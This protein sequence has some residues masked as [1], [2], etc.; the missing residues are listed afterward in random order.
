MMFFCVFERSIY[1]LCLAYLLVI[2]LSTD[3]E[4]SIAWFRP[5]RYMRA[6]LS[7]SFWLPFAT[8]SF[9]LYLFHLQIINTWKA[10]SARA[11]FDG[12]V[13]YEDVRDC[14]FWPIFGSFEY[15]FWVIFIIAIAMSALSFIYV[16]KPG[17][18]ARVVF[19]NKY[20]K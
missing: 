9:S 4:S 3:P 2:M 15:E 18:D 7:W 5:T 11:F 16:E 14:K 10:N 17:I 1:G 20:A 13:S 6:F 19:K 8:L 12:I